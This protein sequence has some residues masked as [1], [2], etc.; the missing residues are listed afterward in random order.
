MHTSFDKIFTSG[1]KIAF[2]GWGTGGHI[3]PI[4]ALYKTFPHLRNDSLWIGGKNS[5]EEI[6]AKKWWIRFFTI[7]TLKLSTTKSPKIFLYPFILLWWVIQACRILREH[8]MQVVFSKWWPGS[9]AVGMAAWILW[10]PLYIHESDTIPGRSNRILGKLAHTIFLGF[11]SAK[12]YFSEE[13]CEIIWQILDPIFRKDSNKIYPSLWQ[14]RK[15]H[16]F[17]ICGSQWSRSIFEEIIKKCRDIDVEWIVSLGNL[18]TGMREY[19][20]KFKNIQLFDWIEK[21]NIVAILSD[22]DICITRWSATTLAE[23]DIF[24]PKKVIIPLPDAAQNHQYFNAI[25]YEKKWDILLE[26]KNL[27]QL[28]EVIIKLCQQ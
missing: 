17:V 4:L 22:T 20:W 19:F 21:E 28:K 11:D 7:Y 5:N 27:T 12:K 2:V 1:K 13:K 26:Q 9:V 25:E 8:Q 15:K 10:L 6:Q 18:N 24:H 16:I 23:I 14:T 3:E